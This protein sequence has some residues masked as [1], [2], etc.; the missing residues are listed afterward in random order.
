MSA[1][2]P[3][4][5]EYLSPVE[6]ALKRAVGGGHGPG[7][8]ELRLQVL[9]AAS[10]RFGGFDLSVF[11]EA[12]GVKSKR[13]VVELLELAAPVASAIERSPIH[14]ALALSALAREA[15]HEQDRKSTG[16]YHTD[17]RLA[18]RLAQL[19]APKLTHKS[20]VIDPASG[21]GILLAALTQA[22]CGMDRAKTAHWLAH[23]VCAADLSANSLRAALLALASFTDDVPALKAMRARWYCGDSL[24]ADRKVWTTMAP[25]GFDA[26]IGNP[27]WEKV[28][29]SRHEFLKSTGT[30][31]HYGAQIHGLDEGRFAQQ[32]DEVANYSRRL[33][34]R[35]P[36]LG[37]GEPDLYIAFTDLFF[38]LCKGQGV[39]AA[40]IP[41]GLI[42]S[43]GT[44]A[45]RQK[46]FDASQSV[47]LSI[48][49]N[50]ARFFAI[51]TRF[52][53]L[54]VALTKAGSEK[55]KREPITLLHERGTLAGLETTGAATIG[56]A[57]LTAVRHDLSL[58]E[59]RSVA[60]WKLFS[61]IAEAGVSW[62][63]PGC[64]WTPKFCREV[65][66]TK[67]RPKFLTRATPGALP[68]VEGRMVQAHRFGVKGHV[69]GTG[70]SALWEAYAIGGSRL[71]PQFW[72][73]P[74]DIPRAN[75][76]R[77]DVLRVGFCDIA[78]Q[79][80][81]RS[82]MA[83][84]VPA[85]VVCGNKVPTILFPDDPSEER[86]LVWVSIANSF[87]FDW[88]LRRVLTTTVNYF[89]LQS[90]PMP[91]IAKDG[92]PWRRLVCAARELR[93]IDSA[94]STRETYARMAQLRGEVD[95]EVA[96]AYGLDLEDMEL[97][98]Q[99]FPI[100]DR[101]QMGLPGEAKSTITRDSVLAA[102]A[103]R[104]GSRSAVW[105]RRAAEAR[106]L[107]AMAYVP[108]ELALGGEEIEE[109]GTQN[110]G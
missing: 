106:A 82:L 90:V 26:V 15:L 44:Q 81:E 70:R 77:A 34:A 28:K 51:D 30:T 64:G 38:E 79:T 68:L 3:V 21:A 73:R 85:G 67:E 94:G 8:F 40:L 101:G 104:T 88:M 9:E 74:S 57:A 16:A 32:R 42:R 2:R 97:V 95:A 83:S 66:M 50:R 93:S 92:L 1:P 54:A 109:Q 102:M 71:S 25:E 22:V 24:M 108:S 35:Y 62:E 84:L 36:D 23:G 69:S 12:F 20:K 89:L 53:F 56:R 107:G 14:P 103:K 6:A 59:V 29:L 17:F 80:N 19:A 55:C 39:V 98:L 87:V 100:L 45:M 72:I 96:V 33:L 7:S 49:D 60:E 31:R 65:D 43:Q 48:I 47:S 5:A 75:Q 10:A 27:P 37:K 4:E 58:P 76:H 110:H 99:D 13:P 41:G 63:E 52:K 11:H 18:T 78:G 61:K 105:S 91:K 86:L 46:I